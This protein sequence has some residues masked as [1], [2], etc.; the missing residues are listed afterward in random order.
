M[1]S[2]VFS[3]GLRGVEGYPVQVEL[4]LAN[5][6][7]GYTTVGLPDSAVRESRERVSSA[8]RNS[9]FRFPQR[10]ITVNL[11]PAQSRKEG[12]HFD[13]PIA[14]AVL[15]ASGQLARESWPERYC[16]VGELALDGSLRP[17]RGILAMALE[18]KARGFEAFVVPARPGR[19]A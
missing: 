5:G 17:V 14:L 2:R 10:R 16:F 18:A 4:D 8:V 9:G 11:A 6:L 13:L 7:P 3:V 15:A 12:T 19:A 1:L